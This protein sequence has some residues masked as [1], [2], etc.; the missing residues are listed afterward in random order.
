MC[1]Y[2]LCGINNRLA[3]Q[4]ETL[5]VH[6]FRTGSIGMGP[7]AMAAKERRPWY[8]IIFDSGRMAAECAVCIPPGA[9]L[10]LR[11]IPPSLQRGLGIRATEEVVFTQ[12]SSEANAYRDAVRFSSGTE[13]LLQHLVPGQQV[14]VIKL[15]VT[16]TS[17]SAQ[18]PQRT[19]VS[20]TRKRGLRHY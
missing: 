1:D 20:N 15:E 11:D 2:S 8:G 14:D 13:L 5:I 9:K 12:L 3:V 18:G 10:R 19:E 6:R 16:E 7:K 17:E 4:G